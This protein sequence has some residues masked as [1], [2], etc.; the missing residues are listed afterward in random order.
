MKSNPICRLS[1]NE[2][3]CLNV[4]LPLS[5]G[6]VMRVV[7]PHAAPEFTLVGLGHHEAGYAFQLVVTIS[8]G[9]RSQRMDITAIATLQHTAG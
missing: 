7:E 1:L 9:L 5:S 8:A 2:E 4:L 3:G 6:T